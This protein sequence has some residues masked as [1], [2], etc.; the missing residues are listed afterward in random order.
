MPSVVAPLG[1]GPQRICEPRTR[2]WTLRRGEIGPG[3]IEQ[4]SIGW[5]RH[6][7][8][9][10]NEMIKFPTKTLIAAA[11][12]AMAVLISVSAAPA[13]FAPPLASGIN[14]DRQTV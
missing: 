13:S 1:N 2:C 7:Q 9:K 5:S 3:R 11:A 14:L 12:G 8:P 4:Q 10:E 6:P